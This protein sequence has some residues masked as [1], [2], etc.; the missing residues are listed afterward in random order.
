VAGRK[1]RPKA[2]SWEGY[3]WEV[4]PGR[5][6]ASLGASRPRATV[7]LDRS[8]QDAAASLKVPAAVG[9]RLISERDDIGCDPGDDALRERVATTQEACC[10]ERAE[11]LV[12]QR[13]YSSAELLSR[14]ERDGYPS[15]TAEALVGR[16]VDV[17]VIDDTRF[18]A[19]FIRSK[20]SQGWGRGRIARE[21]GHRGIQVADVEG[22]PDEFFE[23]DERTR[24]LA[25]CRR[26]S[27]AKRLS[28][29]GTARFLASRGF[30]EGVAVSV[31]RQVAREA[32]QEQA[33]GAS[34][35]D[36]A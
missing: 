8:S 16:Y 18:A 15:E 35:E 30:S 5:Q 17:G 36:P 11:R 28:A 3:S 26:R 22:W 33:E 31:A 29:P 19:V 27:L 13:D 20:A 23:E 21:L 10:R 4:I 6:S 25:I 9:R 12:M 2:L 7:V 34:P 32:E 24:A 14:L 1:P